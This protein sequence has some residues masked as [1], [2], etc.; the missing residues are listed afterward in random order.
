MDR[1][2]SR[3]YRL[4]SSKI[5]ARYPLR[6]RSDSVCEKIDQQ[7][8]QLINERVDQTKKQRVGPRVRLRAS[9]LNEVKTPKSK[10][11]PV[12]NSDSKLSKLNGVKKIPKLKP[13]PVVKSNRKLGPVASVKP[14]KNSTVHAKHLELSDLNDY[15]ILEVLERL[16]LA[17]LCNMAEVS[18]RMKNLSQFWFQVKHRHVNT[19]SLTTSRKKIHLTQIR[20][21][22]YNFGPMITTLRVSR[23]HFDFDDTQYDSPG[24]GQLKLLKLIGKYSSPTILTLS[25]FWFHTNTILELIPIFKTIPTLHYR[26]ISCY[27][28]DQKEFRNFADV[29][30]RMF[31]AL[32]IS[33]KLPQLVQLL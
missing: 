9:K 18:V 8:N 23:K 17:D 11:K 7:I 24:N 14:K 3:S 33:N 22:M 6:S 19:E 30:S 25:H 27:C 26:R 31:N 13:K 15:C 10:S 20:S 16:P 32:G 2:T 29:L 1:R 28:T 5:Q 4:R 21:L 12:I